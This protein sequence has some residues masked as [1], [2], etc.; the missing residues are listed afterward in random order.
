MPLIVK[1]ICSM[2]SNYSTPELQA[3][4]VFGYSSCKSVRLGSMTAMGN[5]SS[6]QLW[7]VRR[8]RTDCRDGVAREIRLSRA[9]SSNQQESG[10]GLARYS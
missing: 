8:A 10:W 4:P 7:H 5:K 2:R 3:M 9:S 1:N 6:S